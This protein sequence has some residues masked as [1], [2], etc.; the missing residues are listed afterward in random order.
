MGIT[1]FRVISILRFV[2]DFCVSVEL[3]VTILINND[4]KHECIK[5]YNS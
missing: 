5:K 3:V 1:I 2:Y 4:M